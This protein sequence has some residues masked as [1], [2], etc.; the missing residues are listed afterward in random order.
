[1]SGQSKIASFL[2]QLA[3]VPA[4][5]TGTAVGQG[6]AVL[7]GQVTDQLG[8]RITGALVT[9]ISEDG[10]EHSAETDEN[11]VY[12][13]RS[14]RPGSYSLRVAQRGFATREQTELFLADGKITGV[15]FVLTASA[16]NQKVTV[17]ADE[18]LGIDPGSNKGAISIKGEDLGAL[19]DD[20]DD[21][22]DFL[23]AL[24][25]PASGPAGADVYIDGFTTPAPLPPDK[26]TIREIVINRNPFSAEYDRIGLARIEI[27]TKPGTGKLHGGADFNFSDDILNSRNPFADTRPSFQRRIFAGNLSGPLVPDKVSFF[28]SVNRREIDESAVIDATV[29][30]NNLNVKALS[31]VVP[32]PQRYLSFNPRLDI[33]M[34]K[35]TALSLRYSYDWSHLLGSGIGGQ[36]LDSAGFDQSSRL[37]QFH[38]TATSILSPNVVNEARLQLFSYR[39]IQSQ[40]NS[41]AT[42][43][44]DGAFTG[45]GAEIGRSSYLQHELEIHNYTTVTDG[46]HTFRFGGRMRAA[47]VNDHNGT[48]T[49]GLYRFGGRLGPELDE[50]DRV[51]LGPDGHPNLVPI[52]SI[53]GYRRTLLFQQM[54]FSPS[55][56]R[57]MGGGAT[58]FIIL[59]GNPDAT[60]RQID[61]G[62][63]VQDD[64]KLRPDFT[65]SLGVRYQN[66]TNAHG[67]LNFAPRA[68]FAW[69]P[70]VRA[71]G[72]PKTV[73][74]GGVGVFYDLVRT[75]T[76]LLATHLNG[77]NQTQFIVS[78]PRA[79]DLFPNAP[80]NALLGSMPK[81]TI[82]V[83]PD[84]GEPYTLQG[85]VSVE[86]SLSR[87]FILTAS[88][89]YS[90]GLHL[91]RE[92]DI[93]APFPGTPGSHG[94]GPFGN[95]DRMNLNES[96]GIFRQ[97]TLIIN[98]SIRPN[99]RI[100]LSASYALGYTKSDGDDN[101]PNN[102]YDLRA[103]FG[104][105][106]F[107]IRHRFLLNG[108]INAPL[109]LSLS[110]F[111]IIQSGAP[112]N[113][114]TGL[115]NNNDTLFL[116]RPAFA[117]DL[118]KP[119]TRVT[120][121]GAF[122]VDP[123]PGDKVIPYNFG[124]SPG[125]FSIN[126]RIGRAFTLGGE[127]KSSNS[128][129]NGK[130]AAVRTYKL[131]AGLF[132]V[133]ILNH[134]NP[135]PLDGNLS[136]PVFGMSSSLQQIGQR[137]PSSNRTINMFLSFNF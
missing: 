39:H 88:Y 73:I 44:V 76:T 10:T 87:S 115:D 108:T 64:W 19:P 45:G 129:S 13:F 57:A 131:T 20:P 100:T 5:I 95:A 77:V 71:T 124:R 106:E 98:A 60:V 80:S 111:V 89:L 135:G 62:V 28:F 2:L 84:F 107:D 81:A 78:D 109:G 36:T 23:N 51:T 132:V 118:S 24:V 3:I 46:R 99:P 18:S 66:Q 9:L 75:G 83:A 119:S 128:Q 65:L 82:R 127:G 91:L 79:L 30:D 110:P 125:Y 41:G 56:I 105:S 15:D 134:T 12:R 72:Q 38:F 40:D 126:L 102:A 68:A 70:W 116:D 96:V 137:S 25:G 114:T 97:S 35:A 53:E 93:N 21:L 14:I 69:T 86:Q 63:F 113:I 120:S 117:T 50:H 11:G 48:G 67:N 104:P 37:H 29:L 33:Q 85:S 16:G 43:Q 123:G 31:Q 92:V 26:Q 17:N 49:D 52:P 54:G 112:L 7:R 94:V 103:D 47:R 42:L 74:R 32:N 121:F 1:M 90:R 101:P 6:A 133:N 61:V 27:F 34:G 55:Q 4:L 136:S 58:Q 8:G 122:N 130:A 22:T 59:T